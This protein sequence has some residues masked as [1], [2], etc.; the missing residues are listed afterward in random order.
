MQVEY[1]NRLRRLCSEECTR[2]VVRDAFGNA[3][4]AIL[5]V[6]PGQHIYTHAADPKFAS[7]LQE[8]GVQKELTI[9]VLT[10]DQINWSPQR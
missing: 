2:V 4:F 5:E 7:I 8:I 1:H 6:G 3:L 10:A 9:N